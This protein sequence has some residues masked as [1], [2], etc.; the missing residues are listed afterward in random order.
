MIDS[1]C[2]L[3]YAALD[4]DRDEVV[5]RAVA[6]GV[7]AVLVAGVDEAQWRRAE[8]LSVRGIDV[9]YAVGVH[10]QAIGARTEDELAALEGWIDR[11]DA[12]AIGEL[13]WDS[14]VAD[15]PMDRQDAV[16]DAQLEIARA[17]DLPVLLH[18]LGSHGHAIERLGRHAPLPAG[19]VVHSFSGSAELVNRYV[20]MNLHVGVGPS[21]TFENARRPIE[22]ARAIPNDRLLIETDAPCQWPADRRDRGEL[23]DLRTVAAAV[24]KARGVSF[25]EIATRTT[26]NTRRLLKMPAP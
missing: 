22:A 25:E 1:H 6:A 12:V 14:K 3:D 13:G 23:A 18:V 7:E 4:H 20:A 9:L 8:A 5:A 10:P 15:A 17:R 21:V 26:A 16:A 11:L 2:H 19:G 24:A